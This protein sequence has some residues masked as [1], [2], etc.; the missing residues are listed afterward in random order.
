VLVALVYYVIYIRPLRGE[1]HSG[2]PQG[3]VTPDHPPH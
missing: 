2:A 3:D 1:A